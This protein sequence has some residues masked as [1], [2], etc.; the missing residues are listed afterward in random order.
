MEP[1]LPERV[2]LDH[3]ATT[4]I[5][6]AAKAAVKAKAKPKPKATP[7]PKAKAKMGAKKKK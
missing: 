2:Y 4:P 3:A 7:K 5:L 1:T 6:P